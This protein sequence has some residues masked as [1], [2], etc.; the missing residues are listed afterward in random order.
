[1]ER[2]AGLPT[3][4]KLDQFLH[5]MLNDT[6]FYARHVMGY[7]TDAMPGLQGEEGKGGIRQYGPHQQMT[8]FMDNFSMSLGILMCPRNAYKSSFVNAF[9]SRCILK[10]PNFKGMLVMHDLQMARERVQV[11]RDHLATNEIVRFFFGD[12]KGKKWEQGN[13]ITSLRQDQGLLDPTLVA[14]AVGAMRTGGHPDVILFDD[15]VHRDNIKTPEAIAG[16]IEDVR[17]YMA[18]RGGMGIVRDIGT[19]YRENDA[20]HFLL[21]QPDWERLILP[22]GYEVQQLDDGRRVLEGEDPVWPHYTRKFLEEQLALGFEYFMSQYKLQVV[23]GIHQSF[24]RHQFTPTPWKREFEDLTGYILTDVSTAEKE[25]ECLN[26]LMYVGLDSRRRVTIF[27]C[28]CGHWGVHEF[29]DRLINMQQRW[30]AKLNHAAVC[31]EQ[32]IATN[33]YKAVI[34]TKAREKGLRVHILLQKRNQGVLSKDERIKAMEPRFANHEV[35]VCSTVPRYWVDINKQRLL[36]DPEGFTDPSTGEKLPDGE[37]VTEFTRFPANV[38]KDIPDA[39]AMIDYMDRQTGEVQCHYRKPSRQVQE[40][41]V[42]R[43]RVQGAKSPGWGTA[44]GF[45]QRAMRNIGG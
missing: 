5:Q 36:W 31:M 37:L 14:A 19:P 27:D 3:G 13:F 29:S 43:K 23:G 25:P 10:Y 45:Y 17:Y 8:E 33:A 7:N 11:V 26:V 15:I 18:L 35:F 30:S 4:E 40:E 6:G 21:E 28:E 22:V 9:W 32:T 24:R 20:H 34:N 38:K 16:V 2:P 1:M 12:L 44:A 39:F 42:T 41:A